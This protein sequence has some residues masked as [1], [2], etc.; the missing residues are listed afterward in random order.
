MKSDL[1][2][3]FIARFGKLPSRIQ[4]LARKNYKLWTKNPS[5]PGLQYKLVG[6]KKPIYS[7]RVSIGWRA[8]GI[9]IEDVRQSVMETLGANMIPEDEAEPGTKQQGRPKS[10]TPAIDAFASQSIVFDNAFAQSPW[11]RTS[12]ASILTGLEPQVHTVHD[13]KDALP[14]KALT[15]AEILSGAGYRTAAFIT[16]QN[17]GTEFG[18]GQGFDTFSNAESRQ[19]RSSELLMGPKGIPVL[20][21]YFIDVFDSL[22]GEVRKFRI[23]QTGAKTLRVVLVAAPAFGEGSRHYVLEAIA[24]KFGDEM[25]VEFEYVDEIPP[26]PSGKHLLTINET[27]PKPTGRGTASQEP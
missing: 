21:E 23:H 13:F 5:Y 25:E 19:R 9:K 15:L 27:S 22:P 24:Q 26:L 14:E 16:N 10:K 6:D 17:V 4:H 20:G 12:I 8:L 18:F 2:R 7:I 1:T 3:D 11:T